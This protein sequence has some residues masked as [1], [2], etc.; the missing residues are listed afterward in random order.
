MNAHHPTPKTLTTDLGGVG[1]DSQYG[2]LDKVDYSQ[3]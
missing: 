3:G 2:L 1:K